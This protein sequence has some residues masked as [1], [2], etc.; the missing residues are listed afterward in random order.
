MF[1]SLNLQNMAFYS[2]SPPPVQLHLASSQPSSPT[3]HSH[4]DDASF[5]SSD[6]DVSFASISV[7]SEPSSPTGEL[8]PQ[9]FNNIFFASPSAAMDISPAPKSQVES[10]PTR[11]SNGRARSNTVGPT[12]TSHTKQESLEHRLFGREVSNAPSRS[13]PSSKS[14]KIAATPVLSI[15]E[16][17]A[18][19]K[20]QS[21]RQRVGLPVT[22]PPLSGTNGS[23]RVTKRNGTIFAVRCFC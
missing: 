17:P 4:I 3:Y 22:W 23:A 5:L 2:S 13:P 18:S 6:L 8:L 1:P 21:G 12:R 16:A 19:T 11:R 10:N 15:F 9:T 7:N 14:I 20:S